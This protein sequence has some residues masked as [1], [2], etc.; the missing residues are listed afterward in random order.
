MKCSYLGPQ[1]I[2]GAALSAFIGAM[3]MRNHKFGTQPAEGGA[4]QN[5]KRLSAAAA[6]PRQGYPYTGASLLLPIGPVLK[7]LL[8]AQNLSKLIILI[9]EEQCENK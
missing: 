5:S 2:S 9:I 6:D 4:G 3:W 7:I 8:K 1:A